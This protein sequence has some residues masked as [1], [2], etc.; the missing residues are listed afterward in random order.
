MLAYMTGDLDSAERAAG[1]ARKFALHESAPTSMLD[2]LTLQGMV[3]HNKGEWFER[4]RNEL[5][6]TESSAELATTIFDCHL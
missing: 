1:E 3:A 5:T 4:M 6:A 2:V